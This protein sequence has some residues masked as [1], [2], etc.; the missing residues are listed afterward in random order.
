LKIGEKFRK[1]IDQSIATHDKLLLILSVHSVASTWVETEVEKA[2]EKERADPEST[3]LFPIR[4][5]DTAMNTQE[6]WAKDVRLSRHIGD[7]T[8]WN[9]EISYDKVFRRL[10]RDLKA[11]SSPPKAEAKAR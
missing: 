1:K 7:F 9:D 11:A 10:L 5:D 2:L 4:L 3:V 8:R 6:A